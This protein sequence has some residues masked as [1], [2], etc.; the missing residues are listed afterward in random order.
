V[1]AQ[2]KPLADITEKA[3]DVLFRELGAADAIRFLGQF[4]TDRGDY[5]AMRDQLFAD[6]TLEQIFSDVK[7]AIK[8]ETPHSPSP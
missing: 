2:S 5:T 8:V 7:G 3:L 4:M 1:I 6:L